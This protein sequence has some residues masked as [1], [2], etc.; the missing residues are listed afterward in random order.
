MYLILGCGSAGSMVGKLRELK[1]EFIIVDTDPKIEEFKKKGINAIKGS[2]A[3]K[4]ILNRA[5]VDKANAVLI[6][7]SDIESNKKVASLVREISP[8]V[9]IIAGVHDAKFEEADV[10]ISPEDVIAEYAISALEEIEFKKKLEKLKKIISEADK[11]IGI[12]TQNSPD[13]DAIASALTL[14]RIIEKNGKRADII[15]GGEIGHEENRALVNL[16]GIKLIRASDV[17][18]FRDYSKIALIEASIPGQNNPLNDEITPDIIIDHHQVDM[19][20]VKGEYIDIQPQVGAGSTILT[21]YLLHLGQEITEELA[22][23]LLYGIK[24]DTQD[25]TRRA[26]PSDLRAVAV[27]YPKA[28]HDLL[29]KIE[30]PF[31]SSE[32]LDILGEAIKNRKIHGSYL[33]SNVGFIRERDALPQ[34]ADYLLRLEGISTVLVYGV[35]KDVVHISARNR[36]IRL[37]LGEAMSKAFGSIG[38]AGGHA[39][40]AA[41]KIPL[42]LFGC[43]KDK[44]SLLKLSKEAVTERFLEVVGASEKE[45]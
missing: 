2:I 20:A 23:A 21:N 45:K 13:P 17:K 37:N 38:Q 31:M 24:T 43:V 18:D 34:A 19:N 40:A 10:V 33:L 7:S 35:G 28:D 1:K 11:G 30:T 12:V 27:L 5:G 22:T 39:T 9:P 3:S 4:K 42:G 8:N 26:T 41:A 36:D 6:L 25:F 32:T 44:T 29:A 16:M 14:K 15:Y